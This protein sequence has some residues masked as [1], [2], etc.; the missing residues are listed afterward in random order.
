MIPSAF[1]CVEGSGF[2]YGWSLISRTLMPRKMYHLENKKASKIETIYHQPLQLSVLIQAPI[3]RISYSIARNEATK[4]LLDNE[5]IYLMV[6]G[7]IAN[8]RVFS[9]QKP[10]K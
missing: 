3:E 1:D 4:R 5:W 9:Y 8:N 2:Y 6:M 7:P 10:M